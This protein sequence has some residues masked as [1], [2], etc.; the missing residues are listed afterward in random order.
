M[1]TNNNQNTSQILT[2]PVPVVNLNE[3]NLP[4][5]PETASEF[6]KTIARYEEGISVE[7]DDTER[8]TLVLLL[9]E[10]ILNMPQDPESDEECYRSDAPTERPQPQFRLTLYG[11]EM[12][13][14]RTLL[15]K[16][17]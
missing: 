10:I 16:V 17:R 7:L 11:Y 3:G 12:R 5:L 6:F 1:P 15:A 13:A 8:E 2:L 14:L 9:K 4:A